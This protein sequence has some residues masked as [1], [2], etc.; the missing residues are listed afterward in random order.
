MYLNSLLQVFSEL[1]AFYKFF[2]RKLNVR[3]NLKQLLTPLWQIL[4]KSEATLSYFEPQET[5][6]LVESLTLENSKAIK[7]KSLACCYNI[8]LVTFLVIYTNYSYTFQTIK[9][10]KN[11]EPS[12]LYTFDTSETNSLHCPLQAFIL[13]S[14]NKLLK[15]LTFL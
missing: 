8:N 1:S 5:S 3:C 7:G 9:Y 15:F 2:L 13:L 6:E 10:I 14:W 12:Y 11:L 4:W